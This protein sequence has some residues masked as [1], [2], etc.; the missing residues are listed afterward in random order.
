VTEHAP[1]GRRGEALGYQQSATAVARVA[2]PPAA[3]ALFDRVGIWSP[4]TAGAVL[5]AVAVG[6][7]VTWGFHRQMPTIAPV[8]C[9]NVRISD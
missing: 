7:V 9:E 3:G 2:G 8:G 1:P 6:L 4:Y 5:C